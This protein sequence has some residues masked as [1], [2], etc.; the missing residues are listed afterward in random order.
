MRYSPDEIKALVLHYGSYEKA[1]KKLGIGKASLVDAA[2]ADIKGKIYRLSDANYEKIYKHWK[3]LGSKSR[4]QIKN[5]E[6][7]LDSMNGHIGVKRAFMNAKQFE[8]EW[9][10]NLYKKQSY[11]RLRAKVFWSK[12]MGKF[13]DKYNWKKGRWSR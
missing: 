2:N 13:Y 7:L 10:N 11:Q 3:R 1:R 12:V 4:A 8:R 5:Y 6:R 9:V